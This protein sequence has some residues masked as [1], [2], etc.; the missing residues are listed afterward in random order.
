MFLKS[1][2]PLLFTSLSCW[3]ILLCCNPGVIDIQPNFVP[4]SVEESDLPEYSRVESNKGFIISLQSD[5]NI[6]SPRPI[7]SNLFSSLAD[8]R[9][10]QPEHHER[11]AAPDERELHRVLQ[12]L[13]EDGPDG[14]AALRPPR[15]LQRQHLPRH[16]A[17]PR[18]AKVD[19][20][21]VVAAGGD[22]VGKRSGT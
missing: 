8:G 9:E 17:E 12:L 11:D 7:D 15:L 13:D 2:S 19:E 4:S 10:E 22:Q 14:G 6:F 3:C 18:A 5:Q 1:G 20:M 21:H 16:P